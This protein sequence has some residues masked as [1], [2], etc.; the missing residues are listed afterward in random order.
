MPQRE[1]NI[2]SPYEEQR[3]LAP[4]S[5]LIIG[6]S[7]EE[8]RDQL[9]PSHMSI[10]RSRCLASCADRKTV[11]GLSLGSLCKPEPFFL[12][13]LFSNGNRTKYS[14]DHIS[15]HVN[16]PRAEM[17]HAFYMKVQTN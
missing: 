11:R 8:K 2:H 3:P 15:H 1:D 16:S 13:T 7:P 4:V 9:Q 5:R 14:T 6:L 12:N 17:N 10:S